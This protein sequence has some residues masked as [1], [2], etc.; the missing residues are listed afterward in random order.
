MI[1]ESAKPN[2]SAYQTM[3]LIVFALATK[4]YTVLKN[5]EI[6]PTLHKA[7]NERTKI[8]FEDIAFKETIEGDVFSE[9]ISMALT[10]LCAF[11]V[12]CHIEPMD[13]YIISIIPCEAKTALQAFDDK[14][15]NI[16][17]E[18]AEFFEKEK[19]NE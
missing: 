17:S 19:N 2:I 14:Y 16:V 4:G 10:R 15:V 1:K 8:L 5:E 18:V 12:L 9:D 3:L 11:G 7:L 13:K 6:V